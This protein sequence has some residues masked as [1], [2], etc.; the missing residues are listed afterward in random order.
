[1]T[2]NCY[3]RNKI[4]NYEKFIKMVLFNRKNND[5]NFNEDLITNIAFHM[6][7]IA[8]DQILVNKYIEKKIK[9]LI[10][11]TMLQTIDQITPVSE[12]EKKEF[13]D[14]NSN[15]SRVG[16]KLSQIEKEL[17]QHKLQDSINS[18]LFYEICLKCNDDNGNS[19]NKTTRNICVHFCL[20]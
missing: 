16:L 6:S 12:Y 4:I 11:N 17:I 19:N 13:S 10:V 18:N 1:M 9:S 3:S 5:N 15:Y 8:N 20:P 7:E 2:T 14:N